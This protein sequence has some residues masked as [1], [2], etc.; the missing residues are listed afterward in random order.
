VEKI[1]KA[2]FDEYY[3]RFARYSGSEGSR[4]EVYKKRLEIG[5]KLSL[6]VRN[7][8]PGIVARIVDE[9]QFQKVYEIFD[10]IAKNSFQAGRQHY[11]SFF[12][13]KRY[14]E[15][16]KKGEQP[17]SD[18]Q[19][20]FQGLDIRE[21]IKRL[22]NLLSNDAVKLPGYFAEFLKI[23]FIG[24]N[25]TTAFLMYQNPREFLMINEKTLNLFDKLGI[26][27]PKDDSY[28]EYDRVRKLATE[29]METS[30]QYSDGGFKDFLDMDWFS[31]LLA[32]GE[33]ERK[34]N[35][36]RKLA[37][38]GA[39]GNKGRE[40]SYQ[41]AIANEIKEHNRTWSSWFFG[42]KEEKRQILE[43]YVQ[44]GEQFNLYFYMS[45]RGGGSGLVEYRLQ[46]DDFKYS[47]DK[48]A[49]PDPEICSKGEKHGWDRAWFQARSI[50][51]L[52]PPLSLDKFQLW[53]DPSKKAQPLQSAFNYVVDLHQ[54]RDLLPSKEK[55]DRAILQVGKQNIDKAELMR[56]VEELL[57][58]EKYRLRPDWREITW[59]KI[60][61]EWREYI[62]E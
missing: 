24:W 57:E 59:S 17:P 48:M 25:L 58:E 61:N 47:S 45:K 18:V 40:Q 39:L 14:Y 12:G 55:V 26:K 62:I 8:F 13:A 51:R 19:S 38:I 9:S 29:A 32:I 11:L 27:R 6:F 46:I 23:Q 4:D 37:L 42:M 35:V 5:Q 7:D 52:N 22:Y 60:C 2:F 1:I 3:P 21:N 15:Y 41:D 54:T 20:K 56:K 44:R 28:E 36:V 10:L 50:E 53:D 49:A 16:T 33:L 31:H 34:E 43:D 30:K